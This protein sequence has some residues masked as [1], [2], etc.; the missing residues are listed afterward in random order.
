MS[1]H[2]LIMVLGGSD[3][4]MFCP[5]LG[6]TSEIGYKM[7]V[8][9]GAIMISGISAWKRMIVGSALVAL[10]FSGGCDNSTGTAPVDPVANLVVTFEPNPSVHFRYGEWAY[11][12]IVTETNG[13]GVHVYGWIRQ[14]YSG[15]GE[16]YSEDVRQELD[17]TDE[18]DDCGGEGN[19]IEPG[20]MRCSDRILVERRNSG[21]QT[22]TFYGVDDSGN[23]VSGMGR[24]DL[25]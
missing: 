23:E 18:F 15:A 12:V 24:L 20:S 13:V 17:F 9:K 25:L 7:S 1:E 3:V 14:G 5:G 8:A 2:S 21:W 6:K 16:K 11:R 19:Y 10:C 4:K 22:F